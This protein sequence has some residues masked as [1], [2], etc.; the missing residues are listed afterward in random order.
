MKKILFILLAALGMEACSSNVI[1]LTVTNPASVNRDVEMVE[2]PLEQIE[3][4]LPIKQGETYIVKNSFS[5]IIPSQVTYDRKIIFQSGLKAEESSGFSI[6]KGKQQSFTPLVY[7]RFIQER[8]DDFAWENDRVAFR[9]YGAALVPVDGASNGLDIW[10]KRTDRLIIDEWY[11]K[12][13]AGEASYHRDNGEG[14]DDYKVGRTLGAGAMAPYVGNK[15]WLNENYIAHEIAENGPL[16]LTFKLTYKDIRVEDNSWNESR[17]FSLDAG[18]QLT[19]V[20]QEY[21]VKESIPVAAGFIKREENDSVIYAKESRY[22]IYSELSPNA[23]K[24]F[25]GMILPD[26][27]DSI[28]TDAYSET[29][30]KE[31]HKH[32]LAVTRY[33]PGKPLVY[34]TGYGWTKYGFS[35]IAGFEKYMTDFSICLKEPFIIVY[36]SK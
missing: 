7:G 26:G 9:I 14:L 6:E 24:A 8:K 22:I 11:K 20:I 19:K 15:L 23:G 4:R 18:S 3:N 1:R 28:K 21:G 34:Y 27:I 30:K 25:L 16:R 12:D 17:T 5:Q 32:I 33:E 31:I 35:E 13:L 36:E 2:I 10:Y 29:G